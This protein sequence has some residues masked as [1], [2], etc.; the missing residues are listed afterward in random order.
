V[1][2]PA[3]AKEDHHD[4]G[5]NR[6][7][8]FNAI[9]STSKVQRDVESSKKKRRVEHATNVMTEDSKRAIRVLLGRLKIPGLYRCV[10]MEVLEEIPEKFLYLFDDPNIPDVEFNTLRDI[11]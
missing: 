10:S 3:V 4:L 8:Y 5:P 6:V 9:T 7:R 1:Q 11:I 2:I